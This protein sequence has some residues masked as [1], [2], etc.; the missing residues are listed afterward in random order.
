MTKRTGLLL[1]NCGIG[2]GVAIFTLGVAL[3][4]QDGLMAQSS[5]RVESSAAVAI[6][7]DQ[8]KMVWK[9]DEQSVVISTFVIPSLGDF[10]TS[11]ATLPRTI[12]IAGS[13]Y[14]LVIYGVVS[15]AFRRHKASE[16]KIESDREPVVKK[17]NG[18]WIITLKP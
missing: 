6:S 13:D 7:R 14:N 18:K 8:T 16:L 17:E 2:I 10:T 3:V 1:C 15:E 5:P 9:T 12:T 4:I 11:V